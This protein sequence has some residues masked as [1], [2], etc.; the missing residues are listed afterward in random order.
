MQ[1]VRIWDCSAAKLLLVTCSGRLLLVFFCSTGTCLQ[2]VC[3]RPQASGEHCT[4]RSTA[5]SCVRI[6]C[7]LSQLAAAVYGLGLALVPSSA[8]AVGAVLSV[9]GLVADFGASQLLMGRHQGSDKLQ[10]PYRVAL[11]SLGSFAL[12]HTSVFGCTQAQS[13]Q[14]WVLVYVLA[15]FVLIGQLAGGKSEQLA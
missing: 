12:T 11:V 15:P 5:K 8:W 4:G 14:R 6:A 2:L 10:T 7:L 1:Q 9:V 13:T 3:C